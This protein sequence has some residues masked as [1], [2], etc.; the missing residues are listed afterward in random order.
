MQ[1]NTNAKQFL[2]RQQVESLTGLSCSTIY[3]KMKTGEFPKPFQI[4]PQSVA[5]LESDIADW[6]AK[7]LVAAGKAA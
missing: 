5:W 6:Q 4:G 1:I 3:A 7:I 2:R